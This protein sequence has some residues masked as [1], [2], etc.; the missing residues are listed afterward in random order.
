MLQSNRE[1]TTTTTSEKNT[2][3]STGATTTIDEPTLMC[4]IAQ[5]MRHRKVKRLNQL[6]QIFQN[7][8]CIEKEKQAI[9]LDL[10]MNDT[11]VDFR[12]AY[13]EA[14]RGEAVS[15]LCNCQVCPLCNAKWIAENTVDEESQEHRPRE[16]Q[17][18]K[19]KKRRKNR[20]IGGG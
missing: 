1:I 9:V 5:S 13:V 10:E 14:L 7:E 3:T 18:Q 11:S 19:K 12:K 8:E 4:N 16:Q 2:T 15:K 17:Q 20:E 6:S